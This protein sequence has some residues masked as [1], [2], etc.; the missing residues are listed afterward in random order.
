MGRA[1]CS[2]R[3]TEGFILGYKKTHPVSLS[4]YCMYSTFLQERQRGH[5]WRTTSRRL[6]SFFDSLL[7]PCLCHPTQRGE[8]VRLEWLAGW[9][10]CVTTVCVRGRERGIH[11]PYYSPNYTLGP[12]NS[13][14]TVCSSQQKQHA[15]T[16]LTA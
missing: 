9:A 2:P 3:A 14:F 4:T 13:Y 1:L 16:V 6:L 7:V 5:I 12:S 8:V 15:R 10:S 11:R